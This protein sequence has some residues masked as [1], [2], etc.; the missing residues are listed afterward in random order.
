M[1]EKDV[2]IL[3]L[4]VWISV[5]AY[6]QIYA[7]TSLL[8]NLLGTHFLLII[9][10]IMK[11][12]YFLKL[13]YFLDRISPKSASL[14]TV[15]QRG[16][17]VIFKNKYTYFVTGK[18]NLVVST[19]KPQPTAALIIIPCYQLLDHMPTQLWQGPRTIVL[20]LWSCLWPCDFVRLL[21]CCL[22]FLALL[23]A[24]SFPFNII[25]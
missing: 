12:E 8:S 19:T 4:P 9:S 15:F 14:K 17:E 18:R 1:L 23:R 10:S 7:Y 16:Y 24:A 3:H 20:E 6:E 21:L 22:V 25:S 13:L 11:K 5:L 2:T